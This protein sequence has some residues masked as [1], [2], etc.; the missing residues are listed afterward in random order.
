[1]PLGRFD[2]PTL[3]DMANIKYDA[4]NDHIK[5]DHL[6]LGHCGQMKAG[7]ELGTEKI[8]PDL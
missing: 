6:V 5:K 4:L 1:M 8:I 3:H 2:N 7:F